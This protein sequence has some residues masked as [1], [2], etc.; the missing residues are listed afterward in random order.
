VRLSSKPVVAAAFSASNDKIALLDARGLSVTVPERGRLAGPRPVRGAYA[1][2]GNA[3]GSRL[4]AAG[5]HVVSV[6]AQR[7]A[8][9]LTLRT[10]EIVRSVAMSP[11][12][13]SVAVGDSGNAVRIWSLGRRGAPVVLRGSQG[14][15]TAVAFSPDGRRLVSGADDGVM[16]VWDWDPSRPPSL[17]GDAADE[18]R[19]FLSS[20]GRL[21][22]LDGLAGSRSVSASRDGRR[23]VAAV[24]PR[25]SA[26]VQFWNGV[27]GSRPRTAEMPRPVN[28]VALSGDGRWVGVA[29]RGGIRVGRWPGKNLRALKP[30]SAGLTE[31]T[32]LA[33]D[34]DGQ[35]V[36]A[37]GYDGK[38][39]KVSVWTLP[40]AE[41]PSSVGFETLGFVPSLVFS[42]DG[43]RLAAAGSDG[44]VTVWN[45]S[46]PA[47]PLVLRGHRGAANS[48][49]FSP[50][51]SEIVSGG[52]DG[53]LRIWELSEDG[54]SVAVPGPGG[55]VTDVAFT[56]DGKEVVAVGVRGIRV[57]KCDFCGPIDD[58]LAMAQRMTTRA[59]SLEERALF[60]HE[61]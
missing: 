11:D 50:D 17:G 12:G 38:N 42:H 35:H 6:W 55:A 24:D 4:A 60:L 56:P 41:A 29:E 54:K 13:E 51:G 40:P 30:A 21:R 49:A 20:D 31:Y 37:A 43:T 1:V 32:A 3:D 8:R 10:P 25:Q 19:V 28:A 18:S 15:V 22:P 7:A 45:L 39:S 57:W 59:L 14:S 52:H 61:R 44:A 46:D 33:F 5:G 2:A 48:A 53:A 34:P 47:A 9:P 36:A 26:A 16:R 23:I 58:V 27:G